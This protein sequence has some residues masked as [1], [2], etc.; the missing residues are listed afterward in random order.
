MARFIMIIVLGGMF[1]FGVNNITL[2][3]TV[4]QGT[5][6]SVD[7][8]SITRAHDIAGSMTDILLMRIANDATYRVNTEATED[9]YGGEVTYSVEDTFFESDN[10]I[11]ISVTGNFYGTI[12]NVITYT[13][14]PSQGWVPSVIRAAWTANGPLNKTISDMYID[15][16]NYDLNG[17]IIPNSGVYGVSTST[18]FENFENGSIGGTRDSIDYP[19]T[20]PEDPN[21]IEENYN[22]DGTFPT[23][24]DEILGYPEGTLKTYSQSGE[25]GS[26]YTTNVDDL[27]D[28]MLSGVTY[29][30][31]PPGQ[32]EK[33]QL[34]DGTHRGILIIHNQ[35]T[36]SRIKQTK[37]ANGRFE[38]I[39]VGDYMFHFHLDVLGAIILLSAD[40]ETEK[41]CTGNLDHQAFY[42]SETIKNSV[43]EIAGTLGAPP[44]YGFAKKRLL[45]K[46]WYE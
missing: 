11:K 33:I 10:L 43:G 37:I 15:G 36:N 19:M 25:N 12:K 22:W 32:E 8:F 18:I 30:E 40:L 9:L 14:D 41:D 31:L 6:N 34:E 44:L 29:L 28:R 39:I 16:R 24:P 20:F 2:N 1:T 3:S 5:Q 38:G 21:V 13:M 4:N 27:K 26:L 45:I 42:S 23:S 7:N 17:N 46:H 35:W